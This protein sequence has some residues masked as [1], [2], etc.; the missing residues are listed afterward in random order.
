MGNTFIKNIFKSNDL[1]QRMLFYESQTTLITE[2]P[3]I[4]KIENRNNQ[5]KEAKNLIQMFK[6]NCIFISGDTLLLIYIANTIECISKLV[7]DIYTYINTTTQVHIFNINIDKS[8]KCE[9]LFTGETVDYYNEKEE[10]Y[11]YMYYIYKRNPQRSFIIKKDK[12]GN[13]VYR[14]VDD[15]K[16]FVSFNIL[17]Y[18]LTDDYIQLIENEYIEDETELFGFKG[19][20]VNEDAIVYWVDIN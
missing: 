19:L 18:A 13:A 8:I 6:P 14:K 7:N 4:I 17:T 2:Q 10:T 3:L 9:D 20:N 15:L 1:Q 5:L 11:N 16:E 12:N